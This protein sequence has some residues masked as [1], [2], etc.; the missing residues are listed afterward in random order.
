MLRNP[1]FHTDFVHVLQGS[2]ADAVRRWED[3]VKI[4]RWDKPFELRLLP[5]G[6]DVAEILLDEIRVK[7]YG[8]IVMGKRGLSRIKRMLLGSVSAAVLHGL[9]DQ[10]LVLID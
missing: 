3:L 5:S 8:T 4:L 6:R 9:T 10:T 7:R 2:A 1:D